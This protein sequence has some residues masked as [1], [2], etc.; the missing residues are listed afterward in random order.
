[1]QHL[2]WQIS[3]KWWD[4]RDWYSH[5]VIEDEDFPVEAHFLQIGP[6]QFHWYEG[7]KG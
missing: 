6:F 3:P 2:E 4:I 5:A 1:M 7:T